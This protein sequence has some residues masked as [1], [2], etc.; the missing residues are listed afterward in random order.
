MMLQSEDTHPKIEAMQMKLLREAGALRRLELMMGL[1]QMSYSLSL[2]GVTS[3]HPEWS[4]HQ[5]RL[6]LAEHIHG[7]ELIDRVR[8]HLSRVR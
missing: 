7:K 4:E 1:T 5:C 8:A 6:K 3:Q 2:S